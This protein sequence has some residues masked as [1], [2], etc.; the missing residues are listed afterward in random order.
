MQLI[1]YPFLEGAAGKG[2]AIS[3]LSSLTIF[4]AIDAADVGKNNWFLPWDWV[5]LLLGDFGM[6]SL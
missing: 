1:A 3:V 4:A 5:D 2:K 6:W